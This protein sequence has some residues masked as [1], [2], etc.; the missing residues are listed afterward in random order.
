MLDV[1]SL[2]GLVEMSRPYQQQSFS[3]TYSQRSPALRQ[4]PLAPLEDHPISAACTCTFPTCLHKGQGKTLPSAINNSHKNVFF[5]FCMSGG[6]RH[7]PAP[8]WAL[9]APL[10]LYYRAR[11]LSDKYR[12]SPPLY[13]RAC[14]RSAELAT[15][16][17]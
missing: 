8:Q 16:D 12:L 6:P 2:C 14:G 15:L 4:T 13:R 17:M 3:P 11:N 1:F 7:T 9:S 10:G 5:Y